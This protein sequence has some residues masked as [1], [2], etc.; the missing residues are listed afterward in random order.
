MLHYN[1]CS[2]LILNRCPTTSPLS[3]H[4]SAPSFRIMHQAP[5][6]KLK[7]TL[8]PSGAM[9]RICTVLFLAFTKASSIS[10]GLFTA[11]PLIYVMITP[12]GIPMRSKNPPSRISVTTTPELMLN[13]S[14]IAVVMGAKVAPSLFYIS[15]SDPESEDPA[16]S[17]PFNVTDVLSILPSRR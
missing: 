14:L 12:G 10:L 3:C 15:L 4:K 6:E 7:A 8:E 13:L 9:P 2:N 17:S 5:R 1:E 16:A 11:R